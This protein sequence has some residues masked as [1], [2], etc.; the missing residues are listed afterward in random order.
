MKPLLYLLVSLFIVTPAFGEQW[1]VEAGFLADFVTGRYHLI[2]RQA[3]GDATY[4]GRVEIFRNG[5]T[6]QIKRTIAGRTVFGSAA[7]E[8]TPIAET[9]VLRLRFKEGA[10]AYECTCLIH[11]DLDNYARISCHIYRQ[12]GSTRQSGLEAWFSIPPQ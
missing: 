7:I 11:G 3:D 4:R 9:P 2:G 5:K 12:D 10:R 1:S 8:N 6:L